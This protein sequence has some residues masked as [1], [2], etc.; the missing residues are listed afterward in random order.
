MPQ[1]Q[2]TLDLPVSADQVW[3]LVG[4][5][6][7]LPDWLPIIRQSLPSENGHVRNLITTDGAVIV[8]RLQSYDAPSR[9]YSYSIV[10]GPF[11]VTD[12]LATLS[13]SATGPDSCTVTWGGYFKP[14]GVT[15]EEV[16]RL[17]QGVYED[18]LAALARHYQA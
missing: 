3:T 13:V 17:F 4:V 5:F 14:V 18:G 8:E 7:S 11:P 1:A 10:E 6:Q 9:T 12:Y 16:E 2:A 15:D